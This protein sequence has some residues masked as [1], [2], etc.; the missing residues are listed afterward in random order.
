YTR[1]IEAFVPGSK[2]PFSTPSRD[3]PAHI[4]ALQVN[5]EA[6]TVLLTRAS[7][8]P[9]MEKAAFYK[10]YRKNFTRTDLYFD[11]LY[12]EKL[13][14]KKL[15]EKQQTIAQRAYA[16]NGHVKLYG[17]KRFPKQPEIGRAHV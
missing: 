12:L 6:Q 10:K 15:I 7:Y 14:F 5:T 3:Y 16:K 9:T 11:T 13:D 17:D 8:K 2:H 1:R 4:E